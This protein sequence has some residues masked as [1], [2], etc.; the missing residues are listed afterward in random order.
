MTVLL[1][2]LGRPAG[3]AGAA[4]DYRAN[5][6]NC[7]T[8]G[9]GPLTGP[10]LKGVTESQDRAW[11][12]R[13]IQDPKG[14]LDSGD[15]LAKQIVDQHNGLVM[16]N[17]SGMTAERAAALLDLIAEE[18]GKEESEFVGLQVTDQPFTAQDV[19]RGRQLFTGQTAFANGGPSCISCHTVQGVKG[20]GGGRLGPELTRVEERLGGRKALAGWLSAPPTPTM[21][22]LFADHTLSTEEILGLVA[23]IEDGAS[24]GGQA[25][26]TSRINVLLLGLAGL[27]ALMLGLDALWKGRRRSTRRELVESAT[28]KGGKA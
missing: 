25:P 20:L 15:A 8:I 26:L 18:S 22:T 7:H 23:F 6:F 24:Q 9:G 1:V 27:V 5:C 2:G 14:M 11:L 4:D 21:K 3:A 10:D 17:V 16:P 12:I 19:A 28:R 13:W